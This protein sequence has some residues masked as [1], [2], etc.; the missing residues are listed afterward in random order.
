MALDDFVP[1]LHRGSPVG[2]LDPGFVDD[3]FIPFR[4]YLELMGRISVASPCLII[5]PRAF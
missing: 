2:R 5:P 4:I 3:P 1:D